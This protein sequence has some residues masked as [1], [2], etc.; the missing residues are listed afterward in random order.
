LTGAKHT[1][2]FSTN[3][4]VDIDKAK[5]NYNQQQHENTKPKHKLHESDDHSLAVIVQCRLKL[6]YDHM[7]SDRE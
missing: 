7:W 3:H 5:H 6:L 4:L 2:E 1:A